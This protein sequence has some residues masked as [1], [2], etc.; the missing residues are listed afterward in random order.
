MHKKSAF[1]GLFILGGLLCV[2]SKGF[3]EPLLEHKDES[4]I[5]DELKDLPPPPQATTLS[6]LKGTFKIE[7]DIR[8]KYKGEALRDG[9]TRLLGTGTDFPNKAFKNEVNIY[10]YYQARRTI[11]QAR[12]KFD[13]TMGNIGGTTNKLS[14]SKAF[15]GQEIFRCSDLSIKAGLGRRPLSEMLDS[16]VAYDA[17]MD[18]GY[19]R[20]TTYTWNFCDLAL[21]LLASIVDLNTNQMAYFGQLS[22]DH[23]M[24]TGIYFNYSVG[25]WYRK[26]TTRITNGSGTPS[27][28]NGISEL[29]NNP[30]NQY[31]TSQFLLGYVMGPWRFNLPFKVYGAFLVNH[32]ARA[33]S[34]LNNKKENTAFYLGTTLGTGKKP[35]GFSI[36]YSYQ[37]VRAQSVHQLD[38]SGIGLGNIRDNSLYGPL[39]NDLTG[40]SIATITPANANG[41]TNFRGW[42]A[43]FLYTFT[44]QC[45]GRLIYKTATPANKKI[46][47]DRHYKKFETQ[48][49]YAF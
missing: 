18:G 1:L 6:G 21:D 38:S 46:G 14:L 16:D 12:L 22:F 8:L 40:T 41:N 24:D 5:A 35:G 26:A 25:D 28:F 10:L 23:I 7:G 4:L 11:G 32:K 13:N 20:F 37:F 31:L 43:G 15:M 27:T 3:S 36:D 47:P 34:F 33:Q 44:K 17:R 42:Q 29:S 49:I 9:N 2:S 45:S 48:L 30:Q 19:L 39:V